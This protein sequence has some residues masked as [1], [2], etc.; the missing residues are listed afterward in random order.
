MYKYENNPFSFFDELLDSNSFEK[1]K[2]IAINQLIENYPDLI[3]S[4]KIDKGIVKLYSDE[5]LS[6]FD[7]EKDFRQE[8]ILESKLLRNNINEAVLVLIKNSHD[9][10]Y[11][12]EQEIK[13]LMFL[14]N[15]TDIYPKH[16]IIREE[17]EKNVVYLTDRYSLKKTYKNLIYSEINTFSFFSIKPNVKQS[18]LGIIYDI[19]IDL[20]II[21]DE[22]VDEKTFI[23]VLT[24]NPTKT[25]DAI[26]F[27]SNNQI[28]VHFLNSIA[29]FFN[30]FTPSKISKSKSFYN[31]QGKVFNQNDIDVANNRLQKNSSPIVIEI[32]NLLN[33]I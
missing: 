33:K 22:V 11:Y 28:S 9:Y 10:K 5:G 29:I 20:G 21:D 16:K 3:H 25:D 4:K 13:H 24:G 31:K 1:R 8:I 30:D 2:H 12:V 18:T 6:I 15:R 32:T 7:Y 27:K 14:I 17:L 19:A 26:I 23:S